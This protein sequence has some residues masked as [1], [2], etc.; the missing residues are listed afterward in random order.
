[1]NELHAPH[2]HPIG[3][4][5]IWRHRIR[6][7]E[8]AI[9]P[10]YTA[11][12]N[13]L[14]AGELVIASIF[15]PGIVCAVD[16]TTGNHRWNGRTGGFAGSTVTFANGTLY[17][18]SS[19]TVYALDA[20]SGQVKWTFCPYGT[21]HEWIYSTP[22][23][24]RK[25]IFVGDRAGKFHCL[26]TGSGETVWWKQMNRSR[27]SDVNATARIHKQSVI[28]ATNAGLAVAYHAA[29]GRQLWRTRLDGPCGWELSIFESKVVV[30]T[31][32]SLYLLDT[33]DGKVVERW[34]WGR[35]VVKAFAVTPRA[36]VVIT[37]TEASWRSVKPDNVDEAATIRGVRPGNV[38]FEHRT[39]KYAWGIRWDRKTG[40][41][42]ESRIDGF[43]ILNATTGE[44]IHNITAKRG[45]LFP[46]LADVKDNVIYL[47]SMSGSLYALNHP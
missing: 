20:T 47:L 34:N 11:R 19:H 45:E 5:T 43:G 12:P 30:P 16:R 2:T 35:S 24:H 32:R 33:E 23:V 46:G 39:S 27:N 25:M 26:D 8:H 10:N 29:T 6:A 4:L 44:R 38:V 31:H 17:A 36:I 7:A 9:L 37:E 13:P 22:T 14:V 42:Y 15:S 21:G 41:L 3:E 18:K 28:V 1:M 40:F